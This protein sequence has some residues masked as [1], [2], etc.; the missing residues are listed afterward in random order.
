MSRKPA[1]RPLAPAARR[2][3]SSSTAR[4]P[5]WVNQ[6]SA[7]TPVMPPPTTT[8]SAVL[9]SAA[10]GRAGGAAQNGAAAGSALNPAQH[11]RPGAEPAIALLQDGEG[12]PGAHLRQS[13]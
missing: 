12:H 11:A 5:R 13:A 1:L 7:L 6:R 3:R 8:T 10:R 4:T 2:S 9:G